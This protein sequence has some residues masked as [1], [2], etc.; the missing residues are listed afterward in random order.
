MKETVSSLLSPESSFKALSIGSSCCTSFSS[1]F[2]MLELSP[3]FSMTFVVL[4]FAVFSSS[5]VLNIG[6]GYRGAAKSWNP[7]IGHTGTD[8]TGL[9]AIGGNRSGDKLLLDVTVR[10]VELMRIPFVAALN[11]LSFNGKFTLRRKHNDQ[12]LSCFLVTAVNF[13][14]NN[15]QNSK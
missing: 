4:E 10:S 14:A 1:L 9:T 13:D 2:N 8:D 3:L 11:M 15:A 7:P 5:S 12:F 6:A